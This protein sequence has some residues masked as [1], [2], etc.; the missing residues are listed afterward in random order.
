MTRN[1]LL[2]AVIGFLFLQCS[3]EQDRFLI[4]ENQVGLL[5]K[6]AKVNQLDSIYQQDSLVTVQEGTDFMQD[7]GQVE[8]YEPGG[9][10]LLLLSPADYNDPSSKISNIQVFDERYKTEKG[11]N[12]NSTFK[13]IKDNY[14]IQSIQNTL[15]SVVVSL[16]ESN[17]YVVI[18]KGQL[19]E[20]LRYDPDLKIEATQIPETATFKYFMV[21]WEY[22]E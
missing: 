12:L 17:A 5:T 1:I 10:K 3:K 6:G 15:S 19:P 7:G 9:K 11:L 2:L 14:T 22:E 20:S 21:G 13:E 16:K 4:T 8:V 18:D